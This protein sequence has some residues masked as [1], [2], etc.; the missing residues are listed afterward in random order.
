MFIAHHN[1]LSLVHLHRS[2]AVSPTLTKWLKLASLGKHTNLLEIE[3]FAVD[4]SIVIT[5]AAS[6]QT[7]QERPAS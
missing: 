4:V 7:N 5:T 2:G 3:L 6:Q 1:S